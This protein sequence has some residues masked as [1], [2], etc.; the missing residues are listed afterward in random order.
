[1]KLYKYIGLFRLL[2]RI[3]VLLLGFASLGVLAFCI[4]YMLGS[5]EETLQ[6]IL[7][8]AVCTFI[9]GGLGIYLIYYGINYDRM[10]A[11]EQ[12]ATLEKERAERRKTAA[13]K[14]EEATRKQ[15]TERLSYIVFT[16]LAT[17]G[18]VYF[19]TEKDIWMIVICGGFAAFSLYMVI[20]NPDTEEVKNLKED[21]RRKQ[22]ID[23]LLD[24][25]KDDGAIVILENIPRLKLIEEAIDSFG[26]EYL[27]RKNGR[28]TVIIWKVDR[29]NYALTFPLG[30]QPDAPANLFWEFYG[31]DMQPIGWFPSR[32][33]KTCGQ[34]TMLCLD[35]DGEIVG[36]TDDGH[37]FATN[38]EEGI[39]YL[40][41]ATDRHLPYRQRPNIRKDNLVKLEIFS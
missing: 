14:L 22:Q 28:N 1:M 39:F 26:D 2:G 16:I 12:E 13:Q 24:D 5:E 6:R 41:P 30:Y 35:E 7:C 10:E 36:V 8:I 17:A 27:G 18:A 20:R 40:A 25:R 33:I 37:H 31:Y 3:V 32:H 11:R 9:F 34:W 19:F 21:A 38:T 15:R 4:H 29:D 23:S